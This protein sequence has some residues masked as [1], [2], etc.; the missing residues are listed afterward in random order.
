MKN[1]DHI[2]ATKSLIRNLVKAG[3]EVD[4]TNLDAAIDAGST[5]TEI[6]MAIRHHAIKLSENPL[7]PEETK[8]ELSTL[9]Q[10]INRSL[11]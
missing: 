2:S 3:L 6:L 4:A 7:L 8:K 5:G 1:F 11:Q 9:I 10:E